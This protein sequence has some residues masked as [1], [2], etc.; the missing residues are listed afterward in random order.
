MER[1]LFLFIGDLR[2]PRPDPIKIII[3]FF[4]INKVLQKMGINGS[5]KKIKWFQVPI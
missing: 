5:V 2:H 3:G 1:T 4:K